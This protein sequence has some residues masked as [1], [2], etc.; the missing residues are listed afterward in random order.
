MSSKKIAG[1]AASPT[2]TRG[3]STKLSASQDKIVYANGRSVIVSAVLN[4]ETLVL[5]GTYRSVT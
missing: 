4:G 1:Y 5:T 2:T 3:V